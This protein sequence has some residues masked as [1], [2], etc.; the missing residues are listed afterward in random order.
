MILI[1]LHA[2]LN[3]T[4]VE[5]LYSRL[6]VD[7]IPTIDNQG[8]LTKDQQ[9]LHAKIIGAELERQGYVEDEDDIYDH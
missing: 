5:L 7:V 3:P 1:K 2:Q 6:P 4:D 9:L 8:P